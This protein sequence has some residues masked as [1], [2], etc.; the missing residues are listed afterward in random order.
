V[1][2]P[3]G[4]LVLSAPF[5]WPLHEEPHDYFRFTRYGLEH[6]MREAGFTRIEVRPDG[7]DHARLCL[8]IIQSVPRWI[9]WPLRIPMNVLGILLDR[10]FHRT[11]LLMNYTVL[12]HAD[13]G[14]RPPR[15]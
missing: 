2:R 7:G 5:Y 6:L 12:A 8:S 9:G 3:G 13:S 11:R 1:L 14:S 4:W 10:L 15:P